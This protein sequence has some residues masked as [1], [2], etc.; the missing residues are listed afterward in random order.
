MNKIKQYI[1]VQGVIFTVIFIATGAA[2]A[3]M[4]INVFSASVKQRHTWERE[5][6]REIDRIFEC[7]DKGGVFI[8]PN[9][10]KRDLFIQLDN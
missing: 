7:R 8:K 9:C 5:Q 6:K 4:A 3:S 1:T 10:F 2:C